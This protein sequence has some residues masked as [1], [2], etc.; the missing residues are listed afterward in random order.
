MPTIDSTDPTPLNIAQQLSIT[1][2][3][4]FFGTVTGMLRLFRGTPPAGWRT[5][6]YGLHR[7]EIM[8][9]RMVE[10][11][12]AHRH[13]VVFFHGGGWMM[14]TKDFYSHDLCFLSDAGYPT[15]NVEYPK[16]PEHPHPWILRSVLKC[17]A[18]VRKSFDAGA[19]VH[20][21]GDS[22]GGNLAAMAG[23][24]ASNPAFIAD[25]DPNFDPATLPEIK[26]VTSLY[27]VLDRHTCLNTGIPGGHTML[28]SYGGNESLG[29]TVDAAHRVTPMDI[30][31]TVHPPCFLGCGDKDI[32]LPSTKVYAARLEAMG[33]PATVRIYDGA[34]HGYF[35]FPDGSV[36]TRSQQD[37]VAFLN[38]V[39]G[40]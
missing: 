34:T 5:V 20:V 38:E 13:P 29:D 32:I 8:D 17:L 36:K 23:V 18:F 11:E 37:I 40:L 16:A 28:E 2:T 10:G 27:G 22:A 14:G 39:E 30:D 19:T 6:R 25:V 12:V 7:D 15:F 31:F 26:S 1:G 24:L 35:N 33:Q 9:I 4:A 3:R 21:M